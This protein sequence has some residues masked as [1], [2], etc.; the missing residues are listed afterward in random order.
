MFNKS[1]FGR[2]MIEMLGVLAIVG[3]LSVGGLAGYTKAMRTNKVNNAVDYVTQAKL[4]YAARLASGT[5]AATTILDCT[6]LLGESRPTGVSACECRS[7]NGT[8]VCPGCCWIKMD[9]VDLLKDLAV[10]VKARQI[11]NENDPVVAIQ[12]YINNDQGNLVSIVF[13]KVNGV[14]RA[15]VGGFRGFYPVCAGN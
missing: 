14:E 10:R 13:C 11:Y 5:V 6:T 3:V 12:N 8:K 2:S 15:V 4:E 9:P 1:Q 7:Q